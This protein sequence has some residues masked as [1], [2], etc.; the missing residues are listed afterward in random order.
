HPLVDAAALAVAPA[1]V[2]LLQEIHIAL[3]IGHGYLPFPTG[4][5]ERTAFAVAIATCTSCRRRLVTASAARSG[6]PASASR[7][8]GRTAASPAPGRSVNLPPT[9]GVRPNGCTH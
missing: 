4:P 2:S 9:A 1:F 7:G 3:F 8:T 6:P 5:S